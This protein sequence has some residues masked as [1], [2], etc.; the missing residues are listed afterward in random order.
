MCD[1]SDLLIFLYILL[2][3]RRQK[4]EATIMKS[5]TRYLEDSKRPLL[6]PN[7]WML[8]T[9]G[10]IL[11]NNK[12]GRLA[13]V[14]LHE[15]ATFFVVSQYME[16][17]AVRSDLDQVLIN[18]KISMLSIVCVVKSNACLYWQKNLIELVDYVT[19]ADIEERND[20]D[21]KRGEIIDSYTKYSRM[22]TYSYWLMVFTTAATV[23]MTPVIIYLSDTYIYKNRAATDAF[24]HIFSSWM[25][26]DK[27]SS[28]GCWI[29][30]VWHLM[31]CIYG[32]S[33]IM[34]FDVT[35][36]VMMVFFGGK[37][38]LLRE[39]CATFLGNI[40][41]KSLSEDEAKSMFRKMHHTHSELMKY[42]PTY[43]LYLYLGVIDK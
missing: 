21:S 24:E 23:C 18:M 20:R 27:E 16:I 28:P 1:T 2:L 17:Y 30:V 26:F 40:E 14:L 41:T 7:M 22:I 15:T 5:F 32:C 43:L 38:D 37:L 12:S 11:P 39:R 19:A 10:M 9:I 13:Y 4:S 34:A 25:P 3:A 29:T 8:E 6:G 35:A 42:V 31:I 36:M 33:T